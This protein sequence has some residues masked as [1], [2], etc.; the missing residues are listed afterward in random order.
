MKALPI[1]TDPVFVKKELSKADQFFLTKIRDERDLPFIYLMIKI[2][3]TLIPSAI[4]LYTPLL[5]GNIWW[6]W[7]AF[8]FILCIVV[9]LGPYTLMLHNTS[10]R[11]FFKKE[12]EIWNKYIPIV[13]GPFMGQSPNLYFI[14]H[15]GMHHNEGNM[16]ED[17][18]STM[19][20]KR[21]SFLGFLHYYLR[22]MA[23]GIIELTQYFFSKKRNALGLKAARSEFS[24][25]IVLVLLC[26]FVNLGATMAV[27]V[28]PLIVVR[29]GMMSGNWGQ[30][31]FVD[32]DNP[33]NDYTS[34]ITCINSAYNRKCFNGYR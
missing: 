1:I 9:Y 14:H 29:L 15:M 10:H 27:F 6:A 16:P 25:L 13:L 26:Y 28:I 24:Y 23:I 8:H 32:P 31:A 12:K 18:S 20:F 17:R 3:L 4:L 5:T 11:P 2:T 34:S 30:H 19:P 22:F 7:A 33:S 21:D